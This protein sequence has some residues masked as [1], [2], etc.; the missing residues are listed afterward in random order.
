MDIQDF[1]HPHF[2]YAVV[3]ATTN[4]D[5]YGY[6]V[7]KD[8]EAG[9]YTVVGVNPKYSA[10]EGI[11]VYPTLADVPGKVDVAIFVV[12]P[13]VGMTLLPQVEEKGITKV[14]LQPG[15]ENKEMIHVAADAGIKMN[16]PGSCIM[17]LRR[18]HTS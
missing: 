7:L 13:D 9:G 1:I 5:K 12:P 4:T 6:K 10:I 8:L 11:P 18:G 15:A 16:D 17:V 3:G 14:W 2:V